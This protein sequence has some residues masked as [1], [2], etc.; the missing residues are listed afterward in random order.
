MKE[1]IEGDRHEEAERFEEEEEGAPHVVTLR[2]AI[3]QQRVSCSTVDLYSASR[4]RLA[5]N[6]VLVFLARGVSARAE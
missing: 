2:A 3:I 1:E 6:S 5:G 4:V